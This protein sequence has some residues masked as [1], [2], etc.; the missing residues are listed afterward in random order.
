MS[1]TNT[2]IILLVIA[3]LLLTYIIYRLPISNTNAKK[4]DS[5]DKVE[6]V[7]TPL[8]WE[9]FID[10]ASSGLVPEQISQLRSV[11]EKPN[12]E[13]NIVA[14]DTVA[15][16]WERFNYPGIAAYYKEK[17]AKQQP[18]EKN[19][20][21]AAYRYFDAFKI[22]TDETERKAMVDAAI[23]NYKKV[24]EFNA[25]NLNAK[26]DLGVLYAEGTSN[27]M[28]GIML[29]REVVAKDPKHENAQMNLGLL[30][31]K[32]NQNDKALERFDNV[33]KINPTRLEIYVYKAYA[34]IAM[35]DTT[36]AKENF[37]LFL[38]HSNDEVAKQQVK[39]YMKEL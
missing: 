33:L 7:A 32:S 14:I 26:T 24:I 16:M 35:K 12:F 18:N 22:A 11:T 17:I 6:A 21:D 4:S 27:P 36:K 25:N 1:V 38:K 9:K 13:K 39:E 15:M 20:L 37:E 19:C 29:L 5:I 34:Y 3:A 10:S 30:S 2:R 23:E 31:M 28:A 8:D